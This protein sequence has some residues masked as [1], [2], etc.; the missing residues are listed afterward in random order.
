MLCYIY[1][2]EDD[3]K[4]ISMKTSDH[5]APLYLQ[6]YREIQKRIENGVYKENELIPSEAS[7]QNEFNVS[8]ITIRRAL[9]DLELAGF[10]KIKKGKGAHVMTQRKY[11]DLVGVSSFSQDIVKLGERPS[12]IILDFEEIPASGVVCDYLQ[13]SEGS[14]VYHLKRLR[15]KN[16]RI[17]GINEQFISQEHGVVIEEDKL[18]E[19]TSVYAL[20]EEQGFHIDRAVETIEAA[21]PS[22]SIRKELYMKEGEPVF[23]RE[24]ITYDHLNRPLEL[25]INDYKADEYKYVIA[26][27]KG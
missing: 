17:I 24:R 2:K 9:Q 26:L 10:I 3:G 25:S 18:D 13:L 21:I 23:R 20:Y 4:G 27:K 16:G 12:S 14:M 5:K 22:A 7:L 19:K 15:L 11:S 1:I 8:R 6:V